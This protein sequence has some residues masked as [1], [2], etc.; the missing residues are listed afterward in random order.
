MGQRQDSKLEQPRAEPEIIPP[1]DPR[2]RTPFDDPDWIA[3]VGPFGFAMLALAIG[4]IAAT[5]L[6]MLVGTL[7]LIAVPFA[8][9]LLGLA[10]IASMLWPRRRSAPFAS[11]VGSARKTPDDPL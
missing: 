11:V 4:A 2:R 5:F 8:A 9:S 10:I 7:L 6:L 1:R 3:K